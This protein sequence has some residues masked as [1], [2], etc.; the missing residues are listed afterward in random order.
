MA[1]EK[2]NESLNVEVQ[3]QNQVNN[4]RSLSKSAPAY[5][6][7]GDYSLALLCTCN[8][9]EKSDD[10]F[11]VTF[12]AKVQATRKPTNVFVKIYNQQTGEVF[13]DPMPFEM[14]LGNYYIYKYNKV[15]RTVGTFNYKYLVQPWDLNQ[16][17]TIKKFDDII[18]TGTYYG[19]DDN[20]LSCFQHYYQGVTNYCCPSSYMM[21]EGCLLRL[22]NGWNSYEVSSTKL[23]EI[24]NNSEGHYSILTTMENYCNT[25]NRNILFADFYQ[26]DDN[27]SNERRVK[28]KTFLLNS[29]SS[30]KFVMVNVNIMNNANIVNDNCYYQ[31][32][33][34]PDLY[35]GS[36]YIRTENEGSKVDKVEV[37]GHVILLIG[38]TT[39]ENHDGIVTYIDP[40]AH[41]R[42]VSN[43]RYVKFSTLLN[44]MRIAGTN[45]IYSALSV[46]FTN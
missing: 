34:N 6:E 16:L 20:I 35:G 43:R 24:I 15:F 18:E 36:G 40:L 28:M 37:V 7:C 23:H 5:E 30:N 3:E 2:E 46:G 45:G 33:G 1:C 31:K 14:K 17:Y 42:T 10:N 12:Y 13:Y 27:L 41:T 8:I 9:A 11:T 19:L 26:P 4:S 25:N 38:I 21:A 32:E 29:L 39:G 44:S 22:K